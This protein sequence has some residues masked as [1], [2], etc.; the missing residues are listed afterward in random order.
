MTFGGQAVT[1]VTVIRS[2]EPDSLGMIPEVRTEVVVT[3][4]RH[5][6]LDAKETPEY[7]TNVATEV[8]KTTAPPE[9]AALAA[10]STGELKVDGETY[11]IS[12]G[13]KPFTDMNGQLFKVTILSQKQAG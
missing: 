11:Q 9:A 8:W 1:F 2:G 3:G 12:G 4:C 5:R 7:M 6:P 13:A 10:D